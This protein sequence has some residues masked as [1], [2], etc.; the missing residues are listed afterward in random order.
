M[1]KVSKLY[2]R[3]FEYIDRNS[4]HIG[5]FRNISAISPI[6]RFTDKKRQ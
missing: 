6:Y 3:F 5:D 4:K 2:R 1:K